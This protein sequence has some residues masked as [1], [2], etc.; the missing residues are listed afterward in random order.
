MLAQVNGKQLAEAPAI[1]TYC[2]K[3]AGIYPEDALSAFLV[4]EVLSAL[5]DL[6]APISL[7]MRERDSEKRKQIRRDA[8]ET[9]FPQILRGLEQRLT[10]NKEGP[11]L[12]GEKVSTADLQMFVFYSVINDKVF[13]SITVEDFSSCPSM[14]MVCEAVR[15][16]PQVAEYYK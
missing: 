1:L 8:A 14:K 2:G 15:S 9:K 7:S 11:F 10:T 3:L 16:L 13:D 6:Q 4:D 12:L 5:Y